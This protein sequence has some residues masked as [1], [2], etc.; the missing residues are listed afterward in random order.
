MGDTYDNYDAF[1]WHDEKQADDLKKRPVCANCGEHIQH[2]HFYMIDG[3]PV[4]PDC[5]EADYRV[6]TDDYID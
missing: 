1:R 4:C 3:E 2:D 6:S 5:L